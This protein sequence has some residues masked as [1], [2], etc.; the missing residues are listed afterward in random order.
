MKKLSVFVFAA[1]GSAFL[2]SVTAW[3]LLSVKEGLDPSLPAGSIESVET[4]YVLTLVDGF[5]AVKQ[6]G[7][8]SPC[9]TYDLP[10]NML[11]EYDRQ[12]LKDGIFCASLEEAERTAEDFVG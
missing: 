2:C 5:V 9:K 4:G 7:E 11:S 12:M 1:I 3:I 6:I 8:A 10:E